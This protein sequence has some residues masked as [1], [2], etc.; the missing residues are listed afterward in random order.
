MVDIL[1]V[2]QRIASASW[3]LFFYLTSFSTKKWLKCKRSTV[4]LL[5]KTVRFPVQRFFPIYFLLTEFASVGLC[6]NNMLGKGDSQS[7]E[8]F[9]GLSITSL[10]QRFCQ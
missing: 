5:W 7:S 3:T 4:W 9:K 2:I 1:S 10:R 8:I 6:R